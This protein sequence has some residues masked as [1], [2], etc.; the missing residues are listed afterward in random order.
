MNGHLQS[1]LLSAFVD[2]ET[3]AAE[4]QSI[5]SH[6][7]TCDACRGRLLATRRVSAALRQVGPVAPPPALAAQLRNRLADSSRASGR[8]GWNGVAPPRGTPGSGE[9]GALLDRLRGW[10]PRWWDLPPLRAS[11][12]RPLGI[13]LAVLMAALVVEH[14]PGP[15]GRGGAAAGWMRQ[16]EFLVSADFG[17]AP[18]VLPQT[19]SQVAG[20]EFVLT[21]NGVWVQRG[22]DASDAREPQARVRVRSPEGRA[23]LAKLGDLEVLLADGSPVVLRYQLETLELSNGS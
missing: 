4:T 22:L 23:L 20:R 7:A 18:T 11:F 15:A 17:E 13:A 6:V 1:E 16:P 21:S 12:S 5:R 19:T 2:G 10:W 8:G 14:H 9:I 3:D